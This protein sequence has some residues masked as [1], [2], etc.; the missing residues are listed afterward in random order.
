MAITSIARTLATRKPLGRAIDVHPA[1]RKAASGI[2]LLIDGQSSAL[3]L[4]GNTNL[5]FGAAGAQPTWTYSRGGQGLGFDGG[6]DCYG[7]IGGVT[8]P[9]AWISCT[10][11]L[12]TDVTTVQMGA[13]LGSAAASFGAF[14]NIYVGTGTINAQ[15]RFQDGAS[16]ATITGPTAVANSTYHCALL[17]RGVSDHILWV[18]GVRY[19]STTTISVLNSLVNCA[20]GSLRRGSSQNYLTGT[21]HY[22]AYGTVDPGEALLQ[23]LSI[24]PYQYLY[25]PRRIRPVMWTTAAAAVGPLFNNTMFDMPN[26]QVTLQ[27]Y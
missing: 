19:T 22:A 7:T 13:A 12:G 16:I 4:L 6:D 27:P 14:F 23:Q 21:V 15:I 9:P 10:F 3:D 1:L 18:N 20:I 24:D 5:A 25:A 8:G 17:T 11:T 26:R 2:Y